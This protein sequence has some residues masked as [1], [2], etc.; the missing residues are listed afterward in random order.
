MNKTNIIYDGVSI[1]IFG[2]DE[3]DK[4]IIS[5]TDEITAYYKIKKAVIKDKGLYCNNISCMI[6]RHLIEGGIPVHF[7]RQISDREQLCRKVDVIPMEVIVRNV[8]AG[9]MAQRLGIEEG[10]VPE[11]TIFDICYKS[12]ELG[13]PI[14]NDYHAI[15]LGLA[16]RGELNEIYGLTKK[17]N[18][19]LKPLFKNIGITL[20]DFKIEFGR[21]PDGSL[22]L[23]DDIT[24][25]SARFWDIETGMKL[26]KD[27]FR[28][29]AGQVG[30]AYR[31]VYERL[32]SVTKNGIGD[33]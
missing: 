18:D 16:T 2:T 29:D 11:E 27:R 7:I 6:F 17:V 1:K 24:P 14:I 20:V 21:L 31:T 3:E 8:I 15:A 5:F 28:H 12:D 9:S 4:V 10:M 13:D 32:A 25:D 19:I 23:A 22:V 30:Q 26:D 33:E